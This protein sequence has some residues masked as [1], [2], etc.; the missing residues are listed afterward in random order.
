[1]ADKKDLRTNSIQIRRALPS[2]DR[3][4]KS[5]K[6]GKK[7]EELD[8]FKNA[9][10]V[11]FY[12][13]HGSEVDTVPLI[14]KW[15]NKKQIYLPRLKSEN[16]FIAL[17]FHNFDA[18]QKNTYGIPEPI[19][20]KDDKGGHEKKLDLIIVPG[21]AFDRKCNRL[22]MGKGFYDRYLS[23]L[24]NIPKIALAFEEQILDEV[25]KDSYDVPINMI[26]TDQN[27]YQI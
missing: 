9:D 24:T 7:L 26:I 17:P 19:E 15:A 5:H 20:H 4:E 3:E 22:G 16:E 14:N 18:L 12:Y 6:I 8:I 1:M 13:T 11:L 10:H 23:H 2:E 21:A 27:T 25:P